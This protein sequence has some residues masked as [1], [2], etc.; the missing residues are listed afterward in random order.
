MGKQELTKEDKRVFG[1]IRKHSITK[2]WLVNSLGIVIAVLL[3]V[4][5]MGLILANSYYK[6]TIR[7][8]LTSKLDGIAS[9]L[10]KYQSSSGFRAEVR[11]VIEKFDEKD[12]YELMAVN[13]TGRA[14]LTSSGFEPSEWMNLDDYREAKNSEA[15][16]CY[17]ELK[18]ESGERVMSYIVMLSG[19][20]YEYSAMRIMTSMDAVHNQMIKLGILFSAVVLAI[21][22]LIFVSGLY[23]IRSIVLPVRRMCET[24]RSYAEGDFRERIEKTEDDEIGELADAINYMASELESS[25][26]MKNEFIS[27]VSHELRTPL[28][29]IKGWSET[30][31]QMPDDPET[32]G[33][34]MR[35]ITG[36]TERLSDMVEEL[37]DFSRIQDGRF[38]LQFETC[39]ILAELGDAVLIYTERAKALGIELKYYEPE[40]LPFV[41][42][43]RARL[44]QVFINI[45]DNAVK[46]SNPGG[47]V[48]VEAYEKKGEIV[49]LVSDTGVGISAED[50]P[51]VK[52][53]FYKANQTRR[54]SGIGLAV[55]DEIVNMHGGS[56]IVN[57]KLGTGT[58]VMITLPG[59]QSGTNQKG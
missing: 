49:V 30:A 36:E 48:S 40:M 37:L 46:Y 24:A 11:N 33:K 53:K 22:M 21:I 34:A 55:A 10:L 42:G 5:V 27:S 1:F 45:I 7:Q 39:D 47:V 4:D 50:L 8:Y 38:T 43:D 58:T 14:T 52:T 20:S 29:A 6:T 51:K 31:L 44:R 41:H 57:S 19:L 59:I 28:T 15:G 17:R 13:S 35:V 12:K 25:D 2:R 26:K 9:E 16:C 56:L 32:V 23:F 3:V 54:G 18:L